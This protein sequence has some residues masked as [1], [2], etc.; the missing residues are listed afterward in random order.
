MIISFTEHPLCQTPCPLPQGT[1]QPAGRRAVIHGRNCDLWQSGLAEY[2]GDREFNLSVRRTMLATSLFY[3][4]VAMTMLTLLVLAV[5]MLRR[6]R[7]MRLRGLGI[8]QLPGTRVG[9]ADQPDGPVWD[10]RTAAASDQFANLFETPILFYVSCLGLIILDAVSPVSFFAA[11]I[12]VV[13]R[14]AHAGIHLTYNLVGHR[15]AAFAVSMV[16]LVTLFISMLIAV[17]SIG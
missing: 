3:P 2:A 15:F 7:C 10:A 9:L 5:M 12:F 6:V 17:F 14:M 4:I 1:D 11:W 13:A 16:A 8:N